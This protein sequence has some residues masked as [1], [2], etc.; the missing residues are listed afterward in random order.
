ME[1]W[2]GGDAAMEGVA[3]LVMGQAVPSGKLSMSFP[4]S[5]GQCPIHYDL[6]PTGRP[7]ST[8]QKFTSRY[9]DCPNEPLYP[10]GYG[11]SYTEFVYSDIQAQKNIVTPEEAL[12]LSVDITNTGFYDA[13]EVV[14]LYLQ[15]VCAHLVSRP[16][17]EL[18]DFRR[19]FI[20]AGETVTVSFTVTE[21]MLRFHNAELEYVSEAGEHV[22]YI[23][24]D[25]VTQREYRFALIK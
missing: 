10:F 16:L 2:L 17:R 7:G 20:K 25:S 6:Y 18:K 14:Q 23:G 24:T 12:V 11:L 5:A 8:T 21:E 4:Y 1:A 3:N 22:A 13:E 9:L 15:D 19:I